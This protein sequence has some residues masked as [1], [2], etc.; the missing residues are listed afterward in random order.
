[1]IF[2]YDTLA[3]PAF[4]NDVLLSYEELK[5]DSYLKHKY[6]FRKRSYSKFSVDKSHH[7]QIIPDSIFVQAEQINTYNGGLLRNYPRLC[8]VI[9]DYVQ[10]FLQFHTVFFSKLTNYQDYEI[11]VHQI[12]ITC[13]NMNEGYPVPEGYHQ[14]GFDFVCIIPVRQNFICGGLHSIRYGSQNGPEILNAQLEKY[15][16]LILNDKHVFHYASP[17]YPKYHDIEGTR[18]SIV[19]T[20]KLSS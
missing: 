17:I 12:R 14:D 18:D 4:S 15:Q 1:M 8:N 7:L 3:T 20:F 6:P 11:G 9:K 16:S 2:T 19:V 13:L 10:Q 5:P